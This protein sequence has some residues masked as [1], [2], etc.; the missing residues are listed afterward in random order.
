M[1]IQL[2]SEKEF[3][4]Q[5]ADD[6]LISPLHVKQQW[7]I[8]SQSFNSI[9]DD[10]EDDLTQDFDIFT[11]STNKGSKKVNM[12]VTQ[13]ETKKSRTNVNNKVDMST[14][15]ILETVYFT[16]DAAMTDTS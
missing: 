8:P 10:P 5:E 7:Y 12:K 6:S 13:S 2:K 4:N 15:N 14:L 9:T 1:I 16:L 11:Q 3:F